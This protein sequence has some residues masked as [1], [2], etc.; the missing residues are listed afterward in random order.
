MNLQARMSEGDPRLYNPSRDVA[1]NFKTV[2]EMVAGR[3]EDGAWPELDKHLK[4]NGITME[5]L[6][7]ACSCYCTYV[8]ISAEGHDTTMLEALTNSKWFE[9]KPLAQTAVLAMIGTV[10]A[11]VHFH[12]VREATLGGVGP[13]ATVGEL[14]DTGARF[15]EIMRTPRWKRRLDGFWKNIKIAVQTLRGKA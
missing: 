5:D 15:V 12:G 8:A 7:E 13:A 9:C 11:G 2:M 14:V 6:G 1:H 3:L 4:A 10:I